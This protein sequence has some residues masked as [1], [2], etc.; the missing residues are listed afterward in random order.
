MTGPSINTVVLSE[1]VRSDPHDMIFQI[2]DMFMHLVHGHLKRRTFDLSFEL[3]RVPDVPDQF[4]TP[5]YGT[6]EH[7]ARKAAC[8]LWSDYYSDSALSYAFVMSAAANGIAP[9]VIRSAVQNRRACLLY[10]SDA[11]DE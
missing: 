9:G 4:L 5:E 7:V 3:R 11:A 10:T 2:M 1:K 6:A 8:C